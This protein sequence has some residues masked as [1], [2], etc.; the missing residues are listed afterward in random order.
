MNEIKNPSRRSVLKTISLGLASIPVVA[1]TGNAYAA[2][3]DALRSALKYKD[4]P[5][6]VAGVEQK[7]S[8]CTHWVAGKDAKALGGCK[9][10]PGD[11]EISPNGHC[12]GW[13]AVAK[14]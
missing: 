7:C 1:M 5:E 11:T 13:G 3:N 9:I 10:L 2:K 12:T 14:K 6:T 4:K 8:N